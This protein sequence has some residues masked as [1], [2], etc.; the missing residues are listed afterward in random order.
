MHHF[1]EPHHQKQGLQRLPPLPLLRGCP[2]PAPRTPPSWHLKHRPLAPPEEAVQVTRLFHHVYH[3]GI[4]V[5]VEDSEEEGVEEG[6]GE[7][8]EEGSGVKERMLVMITTVVGCTYYGI[9]EF[10]VAHGG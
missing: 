7:G 2:T 5:A 10:R 3:V 1:A 4:V 6:V 8:V 9:F